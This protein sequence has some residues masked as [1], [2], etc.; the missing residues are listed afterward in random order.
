[1]ASKVFESGTVIDS[2]WLNDVNA[3][4]YTLLGTG[5]SASLTKEDAR[6]NLGVGYLSFRNKLINAAGNID[7]YGYPSGYYENASNV[8]VTDRWRIPAANQAISWGFLPNGC[9]QWQT[10]VSGLEQVVEG[11]NIEGG[12]Y[13]LN[14][15]G[16]AAGYINNSPV[17][18]GGSVLLPANQP[19]IVKFIGIFAQ[20]QLERGTVPTSFEFRP[21]TYEQLLCQRY[22]YALT[23]GALFFTGMITSAASAIGM[24]ILPT[25][26]RT[27]P[28]MSANLVGCTNATGAPV[29]AQTAT[30]VSGNP[31]AVGIQLTFGPSSGLVA[32]NAT[33]FVGLGPTTFFRFN[34]EL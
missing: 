32:G 12:V 31:R 2:P 17:P 19:V 22:F 18:K 34:A 28:S 21:Y 4:T 27:N 25:A 1:M 24:M 7:Q 13:V 8:Y 6:A 10:G 9:K 11:V 26:M 14:W 15:E 30:N 33:I 16:T 29:A 5:T 23:G 20:P 3:A